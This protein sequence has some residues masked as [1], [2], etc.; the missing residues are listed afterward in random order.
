M[1]NFILINRTFAE[2][3]PESA[4]VGDFSETG[5]IE[6][7]MQVTFSELVDLMKEHNNPSCSPLKT[8]DTSI[9]FSTYNFT[10]DYS[11]GTEREE[12]IH[13]SRNNT[14]NAAKYWAWAAKAAGL[15]NS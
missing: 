6:Q 4:E 15:A 9:W 8:A 10:S 12:S 13:F 2:T 11:T 14:V 7:D 5:F 3:T 1:N